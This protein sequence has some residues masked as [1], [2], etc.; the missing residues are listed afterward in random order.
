MANVLRGDDISV[1]K[2]NLECRALHT[3]TEIVIHIRGSR[4]D[5]CNVRCIPKSISHTRSAVPNGGPTSTFGN[6]IRKDCKGVSAAAT[7]EV[8]QLLQH[9]VSS[10][11]AN[12]SVL[13]EPQQTFDT[14][15]RKT[16]HA[17]VELAV[18]VTTPSTVT[19][20]NHANLC[21]ESYH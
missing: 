9:W 19:C 15:T 2:R 6:I 8:G 17:Y 4:T 18:G 16:N 12:H 14:H 3:A 20:G 7:H 13:E 11:R 21:G 10:W 1:C 5:P